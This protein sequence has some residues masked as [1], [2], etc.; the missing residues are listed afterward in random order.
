MSPAPH[1]VPRAAKGFAVAG[2]VERV[3]VRPLDRPSD[4]PGGTGRFDVRI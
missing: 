1:D 4:G 2:R 3:T